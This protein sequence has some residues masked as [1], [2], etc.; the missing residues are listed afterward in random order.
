[1]WTYQEVEETSGTD[2]YIEYIWFFVFV[3]E[4]LPLEIGKV[5]GLLICVGHL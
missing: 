2:S 5:C 1:M 4:Q 3:V